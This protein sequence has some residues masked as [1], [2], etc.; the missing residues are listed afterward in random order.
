MFALMTAA[1][2]AWTFLWPA[3]DVARVPQ[4]DAIVCLGGGVSANGTL[5]RGVAARIAR[6]VELHG[7]GKAPVVIFTDGPATP[8]GVPGAQRMIDHAIDLG[9]PGA[10]ALRE[11]SAQSTLQNALFSY[12]LVPD[13]TRLILVT[14]A[15]HLP[16]TRA[17]FTWAAHELGR[18]P[19]KL[20]LVMS[21]R[22]RRDPQGRIGWRIL[23]RESIAIWF[24][25]GRAAAYS[26]APDP[27]IDWLR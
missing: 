8:G 1:M 22:V 12:P 25:I 6:C 3:P 27:D 15:F 21:E 17:S 9:L 24:N 16:R 7:A 20:H 23:A 4:A 18:S 26:L 10:A 13:A 11:G 2:L 5:G 19:P 14:E